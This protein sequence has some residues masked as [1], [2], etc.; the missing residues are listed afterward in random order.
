MSNPTV[1]ISFSSHELPLARELAQEL[2]KSTTTTLWTEG[3]FSSRKSIA[4]ALIESANRADFAIFLIS[5]D[6]VSNERPSARNNTLFE[7]GLFIGRLGPSRVFIIH[8]QENGAAPSDLAGLPVTTADSSTISQAAAEIRQS[9]ATIGVRPDRSPSTYYSCFISSSSKDRDFSTRLRGHLQS[10]GILSSLGDEYLK[11][12]DPLRETINN[13][14]EAHDK[15]LLI[16]SQNSIKSAWIRDN[17][18]KALELEA[19]RRKTIL[20]PIRLDDTIFEVS[21]IQEIEQL[22]LRSIADFR[23]WQNENLFRRAFSQLVRDLTI[24]ASVEAGGMT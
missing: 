18:R 7:L 14:T 17:V 16:L 1:F 5:G 8:D 2:A 4:D 24:S 23:Q 10:V 12:S 11:I 22:K 6:Y 21:G 19:E 15:L 20:F 3:I 13:P 9:I